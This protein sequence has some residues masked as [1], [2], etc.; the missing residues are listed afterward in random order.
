MFVSFL[1]LLTGIATHMII[2]QL[3]C[4]GDTTCGILFVYK[5]IRSKVDV[6]LGI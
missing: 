4:A 5:C 2:T 6:L 3:I 1:L